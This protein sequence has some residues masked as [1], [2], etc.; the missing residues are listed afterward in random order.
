MARLLFPIFLEC[1]FVPNAYVILL[2]VLM[3]TND[4][5]ECDATSTQLENGWVIDLLLRSGIAILNPTTDVRPMIP[6]EPEIEH[7]QDLIIPDQ[8]ESSSYIHLPNSV[9]SNEEAEPSSLQLT[10]E[11]IF[12]SENSPQTFLSST[13]MDIES[14]LLLNQTRIRDDIKLSS[15][16]VTTETHEELSLIHI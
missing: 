11:Q 12:T 4:Q 2:A 1:Q 13:G 6:T 7:Q 16:E 14:D 10:Q 3:D 8:A 5:I 9:W 15:I